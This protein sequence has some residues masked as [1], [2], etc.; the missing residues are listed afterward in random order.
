PRQVRWL[1]CA[2]DTPKR[3]IVCTHIPPVQLKCWTAYAGARALASFE[4]GALEFTRVVSRRGVDRVY[5]GHIH[6]FGVQD[7]EGVRYI[8]TGG[9]GSPLFP[10]GVVDRCHHYLVAT[11]SPGGVK[12][13]VHA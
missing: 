2:L 6:A 12:E 13:T 11:V 9:G 5:I 3:K 8:L 1:D 10:S 4:E 7:F